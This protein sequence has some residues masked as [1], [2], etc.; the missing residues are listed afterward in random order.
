MT[1][2]SARPARSGA[3]TS[4]FAKVK[5]D[6]N[7]G[8]TG[9]R[10]E[11]VGYMPTI[12]GI[13]MKIARRAPAQG[14]HSGAIPVLFRPDSLEIPMKTRAAIA[15]KAGEPLAVTDVELEGPH[16]GE[17]LVEICATGICHTDAF[18]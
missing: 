1:S 14:A 5:P 7:G 8:Q 17:V 6:R 11:R 9:N 4:I 3:S 2:A 10:R 13:W 15:W 18:T 16:A 12:C